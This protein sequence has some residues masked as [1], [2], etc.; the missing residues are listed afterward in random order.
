MSLSHVAETLVD[1]NSHK[2]VENGQGVSTHQCFPA[3]VDL[4]DSTTDWGNMV[5]RLC[6]SEP[7][8][9]FMH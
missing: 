8:S 7:F 1:M 9:K 6:S 2:G 3:P 5:L 4:P